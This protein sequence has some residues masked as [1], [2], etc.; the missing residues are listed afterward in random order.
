MD[1]FKISSSFILRD[2]TKSI[3]PFDNYVTLPGSLVLINRQPMTLRHWL[4][5]ARLWG[6]PRR[7]NDVIIDIRHLD[8]VY[9][10]PE[11]FDFHLACW[12]VILIFQA[13]LRERQLHRLLS[14]KA[15]F[16]KKGNSCRLVQEEWMASCVIKGLLY[17]ITEACSYVYRDITCTTFTHR[18]YHFLSS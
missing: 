18:S 17:K 12:L 16:W 11:W 15:I 9:Y 6:I 7:K 13:V 4:M 2:G 8:I 3:H 14:T 1:S 10:L 5:K